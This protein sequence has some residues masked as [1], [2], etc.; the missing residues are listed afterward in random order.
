MNTK[1][2]I[3]I[4]SLLTLI[5]FSYCY[6][7]SDMKNVTEKSLETYSREDGEKGCLALYDTG[8]N[9]SEVCNQ[10]ILKDPYKCCYVYYEIGSDYKNSF[11]MPI[12]NNI[13]AIDDVKHAFRNA[14]ELEIDC[15][16]SFINV[17]Y[18]IFF[19]IIFLM[20]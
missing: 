8:A 17:L 13:K 5:K 16:A 20:Y 15:G 10:F 4:I 11:C 1:F 7:S 6:N 3:T 2:I 12:V 18:I 9:S 19:G 14:D